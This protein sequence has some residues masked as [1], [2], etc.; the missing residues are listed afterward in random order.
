MNS[1]AEV[2]S[3]YA[4]LAELAAMKQQ[5]PSAQDAARAK[6][7]RKID[8][9][10]GGPFVA[11]PWLQKEE[12]KEE[13]HEEKEENE[14]PDT[15]M[16]GL[17]SKSDTQPTKDTTMQITTTD[18]AL[19]LAYG[20]AIEAYPDEQARIFK[21]AKIA[22]IPF[23]VL[24]HDGYTTVKSTDG[25]REYTVNGTCNCPDPTPRCK[26]VWAK[27]LHRKMASIHHAMLMPENQHTAEVGT[28]RGIV[29]IVDEAWFH[30]PYGGPRGQFTNS[31]ECV[32]GSQ[33]TEWAT[34]KAE[35][36][37]YEAAY[38]LEHGEIA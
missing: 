24:E 9:E 2:V 31:A 33:G 5:P 8:A 36:E 35:Q 19:T 34:M 20:K 22:K 17:T 28:D 23:D 25:A 29:H 10:T 1:P 15:G 18:A 4:E 26:H 7:Q 21:G 37:K 30:V 12:K 6:E 27:A 13:E 11:P 38:W 14:R 32:K 16:P 3:Y